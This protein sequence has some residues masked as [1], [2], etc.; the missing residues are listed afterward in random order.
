MTLRILCPDISMAKDAWRHE[1][2]ALTLSPPLCTK[3]DIKD[4]L[5]VALSGVR[6][7]C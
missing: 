4:A 6:R 7:T 2:D 3:Y 1:F 5:Q